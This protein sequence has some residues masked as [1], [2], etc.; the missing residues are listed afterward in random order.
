MSDNRNPAGSGPIDAVILWVDGSDATLHYLTHLL[1]VMAQEVFQGL[2]VVERQEQGPV[3]TSLSDVAGLDG[4]VGSCKM[5]AEDG[6][7]LRKLQK[8]IDDG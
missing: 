8:V 5:W 6:L 3:P 7:K 2:V 4:L 1:T